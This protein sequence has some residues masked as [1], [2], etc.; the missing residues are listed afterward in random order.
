LLKVLDST[1]E[2]EI[3]LRLEWLIL[4]ISYGFGV[5]I[6]PGLHQVLKPHNLALGSP[7]GEGVLIFKFAFNRVE[8]LVE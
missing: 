2:R 7:R 8:I 4:E 6:L 1:L 3:R 5:G